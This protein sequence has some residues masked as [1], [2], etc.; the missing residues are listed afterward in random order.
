MIQFLLNDTPVSIESCSPSLTVLDW[1]RTTKGKTGTKEGCATGDCGACTLLIGEHVSW[2]NSDVQ[3]QYKTL[4]S[5]LM[6]LGNAH[7]KHII[8][9]EALTSS[10]QV[11]LQQ[12]HPVQRAM[13]ECHGSQCGFCTP[14]IVMSLL[15][16][17][18]NNE[19]YPGKSATIHALGGNL[20]RCTGY[21]PILKA[22]EKAFEYERVEQPWSAL[23]KKFSKTVL[24]QQTSNTV[25]FLTHN[26]RT[27]HIPQSAE[28]LVDLKS[29]LPN[30][31]L[32]A[33]ATDF[34]IEL[35]QNLL[36][37]DVLISVSQVAELNKLEQTDT[38]L[39][40]GA[41]LPYSDF[42]DTL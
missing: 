35:S 11:S 32:V 19:S 9:V 8:T 38:A 6:L 27:F 23:A 34:A 18:I 2:H 14:G 39:E 30:S 3:W 1:L 25:P 13:V 5:C 7:G 16:L 15:A 10:M 40:I 12:L 24:Q 28:Q 22:A 31:S 26:D 20:C 21:N 42:V 41:A 37:P 17:Y 29:K 36:L 4:N 33:G